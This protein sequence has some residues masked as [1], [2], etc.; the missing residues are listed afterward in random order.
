MSDVKAVAGQ[1]IFIGTDPVDLGDEDLILSDF[2]GVVWIEIK[3][4]QTMGANG[5]AAALI[6]TPLINRARDNKQKGT[7]NAG[8]MQN[9]FALDRGDAG[10]TKL[11][12]AEASD[13]NYPFKILGNDEPAV[14]SAPTPSQRL[15]YGLV[16]S[17]TEQGG[18]ANTA[19]MLQATTEINT[20]IV[21][22]L[23]SAGAAPTNITKPAIAGIAQ[24]GVVLTCWP[25]IWTGGV[26]SYAYQWKNEGANISGATASTYTPVSG[27]VGDNITVTVT[28]TNTAGS[29]SATSA[30]TTAVLAP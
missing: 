14:G 23:P 15:F 20:N 7:R 16:M 21:T 28:A 1:R 13:L 22:V 3:G 24:Q 8:S 9:V 18:Q 11:R 19:Q 5:D 6:T 30:E 29:T 26:D 27:D 12:E 25:G 2:S 10:Q 17:A 4:W